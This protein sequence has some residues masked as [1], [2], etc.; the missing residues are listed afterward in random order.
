MFAAEVN[1]RVEEALFRE[2]KPDDYKCLLFVAGLQSA[3]DTA[4]RTRLLRK[5]ET[6]DACTLQ[7]L[8][9]ECEAFESMNADVAVVGTPI[10]DYTVAPVRKHK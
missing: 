4:I 9:L 5:L 10:A 8:L 3:Q 6:K 1:K 2:M 7:D